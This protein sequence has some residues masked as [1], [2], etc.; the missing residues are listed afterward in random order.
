MY[1]GQIVEQAPVGKLISMPAHPYTRLLLASQ[2]RPSTP[3]GLDLPTIPGNVADPSAWPSSCRFAE[4]CP[5]A[6]AECSQQPIAVQ[7]LGGGRE[8]RCIHIDQVVP[9]VSAHVG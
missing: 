1:A 4:R 2:P 5:L 9:E 8:S 7:S 3:R 6:T